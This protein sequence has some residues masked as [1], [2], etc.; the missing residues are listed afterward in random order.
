MTQ[1]ADPRGG[2]CPRCYEA[3][4]E[5]VCAGFVIVKPGGRSAVAVPPLPPGMAESVREASRAVLGTRG[6]GIA[7]RHPHVVKNLSPPRDP[8]RA[9][10]TG[11]RT[12]WLRPGEAVRR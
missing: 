7:S 8:A 11:N 9:L 10:G 12:I 4:I 3:G 2:W 1:L 5:R 6:D